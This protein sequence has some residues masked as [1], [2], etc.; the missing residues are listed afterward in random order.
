M[1]RL[2]VIVTLIAGIVL[3]LSAQYQDRFKNTWIEPGAVSHCPS[4][5]RLTASTARS[6]CSTPRAP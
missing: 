4:S 6:A 5:M 1:R 2:L 3:T